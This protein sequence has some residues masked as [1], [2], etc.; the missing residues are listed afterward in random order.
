MKMTFFKDD[1]R[2]WDALS[3]KRKIIYI[4]VGFFVLYFL[5][6][7]AVMPL[8]TRQY[9][10]IPVPDVM[11]LTYQAAERRL[12]EAGLRVVKGSEQYH[13][14]T[15]AGDVLFQV[16]EAGT[17]VKKGRRVYLTIS[18]G[19]KL[20]AMPKLV[21]ISERDARFALQESELLLGT[22]DYR[23]DEFYPEGVV[24]GQSI[25]PGA[26]IRFGTRVDLSVSVGIEP[27]E[28]IVPEVVGLSLDQAVQLIR[29]AGLTPGQIT[30]QSTGKL[31]PNTVISQS[32][33][34]GTSV[35]KGDTLAMIISILEE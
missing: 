18:K 19:H 20:L 34:A 7:W 30:E 27:S 28:F 5:L 26:D 3:W 14:E 23:T 29:K 33:E 32:L 10:S 6:D 12:R 1:L 16:P 25:S 13:E 2:N 22:I 21:G 35:S 17:P 11:N 24:C 15:V 31:L 9:Q 8:Y 4:A